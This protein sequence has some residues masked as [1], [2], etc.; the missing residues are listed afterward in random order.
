LLAVASICSD[1]ASAGASTG[2][3]NGRGPA[4][5][6]SAHPNLAAATTMAAATPL[7]TGF[8]YRGA[9]AAGHEA[10]YK[11]EGGGQRAYVEVRGETP[12]CS[13]RA[14]LLDARSRTLRQIISSTRETLPLIAYFPSKPVTDVYYLRIDANPYAPCASASFV[15]V[16]V[17]PVQA[18]DCESET[19]VGPAG[20]PQ[21]TVCAANETSA[22]PSRERAC[23][24]DELA[25]ER[26]STA[27][28]RERALVTRRRGSIRTLRQYEGRKDAIK[29]R[30]LGDCVG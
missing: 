29:R 10:W 5:S 14:T 12:S 1:V 3:P 18:D 4:A 8:D 24:A 25:L 23:A 15:F 22:I 28:A 21:H 26:E 6:K 2:P 13:V 9:V 11:L 16:L 7:K 27:I 30:A 17:Q 20:E 19:T